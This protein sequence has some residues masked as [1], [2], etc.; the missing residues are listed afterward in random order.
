MTEV[1][2]A[3][4]HGFLGLCNRAGQVILGQDAC[5]EAVRRRSVSVVLLDAGC[6]ENTRKR[7]LDT[8]GTHQI[9]LYELEANKIAYAVGKDG[10]MVA[11]IKKGGM[12]DKV[13]TLL[14][15]EDDLSREQDTGTTADD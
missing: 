4:I 3:Q 6:S 5:V 8:C 13:L 15:D 9:P 11:A 7:F 1:V 12:A 14:K 2:A 10:R